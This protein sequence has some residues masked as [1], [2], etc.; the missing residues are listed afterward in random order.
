MLAM[1]L[2][3][4]LPGGVVLTAPPDPPGPHLPARPGPI[5]APALGQAIVSPRRRQPQRGRRHN[6]PFCAARPKRAHHRNG[7]HSQRSGTGRAWVRIT[8]SSYA[9][10]AMNAQ[11]ADLVDSGPWSI[12]AGAVPDLD[13]LRAYDLMA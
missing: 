6:W 12:E 11:V 4:A 5:R 1:I 8:L 2:L 13:V 10:S 7:A 3:T 9:S